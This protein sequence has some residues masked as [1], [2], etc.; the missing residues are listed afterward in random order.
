MH[1]VIGFPQELENLFLGEDF[2]LFR[3]IAIRLALQ[4]R[5]QASETGNVYAHFQVDCGPQHGELAPLCR[6]PLIFQFL[7]KIGQQTVFVDGLDPIPGL[8]L[9][10]LFKGRFVQRL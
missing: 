7:G 6:R 8:P 10:K 9:L 3:T 4:Q 2:G 5:L 1:R